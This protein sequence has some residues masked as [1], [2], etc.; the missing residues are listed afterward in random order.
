M[1]FGDWKTEALKIMPL[2]TEEELQ[3]FWDDF[4]STDT[5]N[6]SILFTFEE[7]DQALDKVREKQSTYQTMLDNKFQSVHLS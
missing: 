3:K 4:K 2:A 5:N 1:T 6:D 7:F